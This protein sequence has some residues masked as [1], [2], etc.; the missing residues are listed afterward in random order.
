[1]AVKYFKNNK[2]RFAV[3]PSIFF[4][5][6]WFR[7]WVISGF[8]WM[9]LG[10]INEFLWGALPVVG[11]AGTSFI[12]ILVIA[13]FFEKNN[14]VFARSAGVLLC[15]L[16]AFGPGYTQKGGE[17]QLKISVICQVVIS[18]CGSVSMYE[19]ILDLCLHL[20]LIRLIHLL[21]SANNHLARA[22]NMCQ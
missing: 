3:L 9:N 21:H 20:S 12:I 15:M 6:E 11:A 8:P 14:K 18:I 10:A 17:D 22:I 19:H 4:L 2:Y 16:M 7:S 5:L 13:L 1:M